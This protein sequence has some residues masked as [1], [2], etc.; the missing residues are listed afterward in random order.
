MPDWLIDTVIAAAFIAS[1]AL[2]I[3]YKLRQRQGHQAAFR[4]LARQLGL[5]FHATHLGQRAG[6]APTAE[7]AE[8]QHS[9]VGRAGLK[10]LSALPAASQFEIDGQID[11]FVVRIGLQQRNKGQLLT[12]AA[13]KLPEPL[14]LGLVMHAP[15][16]LDRAL[17]PLVNAGEGSAEIKLGRAEFDQAVSLRSTKARAE[18]ARRLLADGPLQRA[19]LALLKAQPTAW[20]DDDAVQIHLAG[21]VTDAAVW[22]RT[23]ALMTALARALQAAQQSPL[24]H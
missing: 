14:G 16:G 19:T 8:L 9:A 20:V 21:V 18:S 12:H 2:F 15:S 3:R 22:R 24:R 7:L 1:A 6:Q 23:L 11:G 13:V 5:N 4:G 10:V 17:A